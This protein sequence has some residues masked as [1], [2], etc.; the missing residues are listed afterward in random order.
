MDAFKSATLRK[1]PRRMAVLSRWPNQRSTKFIQ[2]ELG[3][4][5]VG[6]EPGIALQPRLHCGMLVRA[7]GV[8]DPMQ[9]NIARELG[10]DAAQEFQKLLMAM[11]LMAFADHLAL[12][13]LQGGE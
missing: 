13:R 5:E 6:H 4:D 9:G 3:G 11:S 1:T 10:I 12:H 2:L 7:V 8:P